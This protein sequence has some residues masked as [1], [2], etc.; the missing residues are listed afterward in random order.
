MDSIP[1]FLKLIK[2]HTLLYAIITTNNLSLVKE[3]YDGKYYYSSDKCVEMSDFALTDDDKFSI[4]TIMIQ[5]DS[6]LLIFM[7]TDSSKYYENASFYFGEKT[8]YSPIDS[9]LKE[10]NI[11]IKNK[12]KYRFLDFEPPVFIFTKPSVKD[13][14][15]SLQFG[16]VV[17][18]YNAF[19]II[20]KKN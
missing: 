19:D 9:I 12:L 7:N 11:E 17:R 1:L 6:S 20:D 15:I 18:N 10:K 3:K 4:V 16:E 13:F 8:I 5:A 14:Y 2:A